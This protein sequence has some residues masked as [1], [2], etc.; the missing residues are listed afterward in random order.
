[1][2]ISTTARLQVA[3]VWA[4]LV[5][6]CAA[7]APA[8]A[9]SDPL[10][11]EAQRL[12]AQR[13][14]PRAYELLAAQEADRAGDPMFDYLFGIAAL[15]SGRVADAIA[16]LERVLAAQPGFAGARME[17]ARAL[18]EKGELAE[19][20]GQFQALLA[21]APPPQTQ[22]VIE[23]YLAA[24]D[25]GRGVAG[26]K[27]TPSFDFG[28][29]YDSNAN[30][31]TSES[32][33]LGFTLNPRN[34]EQ[35]SS[36]LEVGA[37]LGHSR[38]FGA[39]TGIASSI[40]LSHRYNPDAPYVDQSIASLAS[41][42]LFKTGETRG[43]IGI[44]GFYGLLDGEDHQT[45]ANLEFGLARRF[46]GD[47]EISGLARLGRVDYRQPVLAIMEVDRVLGGVA[48]TR[49]S[50]GDRSGRLGLAVIGGQDDAR[51]TNSPYGNDRY[52]ARLFGGMLLRPQST[53]Y[54]EIS[55]QQSDFKGGGGF[56]GSD[57]VDDQ[58]AVVL[59]LDLQNWPGVGWSL[60]PQLRYTN[61]DSNVSLYQF[62]R[63]EA[64]VF[65]RRSFR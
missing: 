54:A 62:S 64:A 12:I 34:V 7:F 18:Y 53:L 37:G 33:F 59:G 52:G 63:T 19:A 17:Y 6:I 9:Q 5:T 57:R 43:S 47:W 29:G 4:L 13:D 48:L 50:L 32:Q 61:N 11:A 28:M 51:R 60:S 30:G 41:S 15:D 25:R 35:E 31:S 46:A 40:R 26:S 49:Y 24:I 44:N 20:H 3:C 58:T 23:R 56:F 8:Q 39:R 21:Q 10:V 2:L 45:Q 55:Y 14:A 36:F 27:F 42:W 1:M 22:A 16:P 65:V 38:A